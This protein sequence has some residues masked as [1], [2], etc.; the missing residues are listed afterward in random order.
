MGAGEDLLVLFPWL[1]DAFDRKHRFEAPSARDDEAEHTGADHRDLQHVSA[2]V[3]EDAMTSF[4]A[5]R[6]PT[7]WRNAHQISALAFSEDTELWLQLAP[8]VTPYNAA[9]AQ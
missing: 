9:Q 4:H 5:A 2:E 3:V 6:G 8:P 1:G 7:G